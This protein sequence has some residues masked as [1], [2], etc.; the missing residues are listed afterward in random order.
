MTWWPS[1]VSSLARCRR[2]DAL[3]SAVRVAPVDQPGDAET[4]GLSGMSGTVSQTAPRNDER[5][6]QGS[7]GRV[8]P[9]AH[10]VA[11]DLVTGISAAALARSRILGEARWSPGGTRLAWLDAFGGRVDLVVGPADGSGPDVTSP[12]RSRSPASVR[13]GAVA[14]AGSTTTAGLRRRRRP[15]PR[16]ACRA[17]V[18]CRCCRATGVPAAPA[19]SPDGTRVAFVIE[20]DDACDIAVVDA[21]R[22][23]VAPAHVARRL[24]LGPDVVGRRPHAGLARVG[25]AQHAVGRVAH[26][27]RRGRR[28]RRGRDARRRR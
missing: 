16:R 2:V 15:A 26:H 5:A 1:S 4:V 19:A 17:A 11:S 8:T 25:S 9:A 20:R 22:R 21:R 12:P 6:G 23:R 3:S 10:L 14:T 27:G 13:T 7:A 28:C 24:R 18:G